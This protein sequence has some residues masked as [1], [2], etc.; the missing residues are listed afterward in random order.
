MKNRYRRV[1]AKALAALAWASAASILLPTR[2]MAATTGGALP[3]DTT[4]QTLSDDIQGPVA[5]AVTA[6]A[7]VMG[8][9]LWAVSEHGQGVRK[10]SAI[11]MGGAMALGALQVMAALFPTSAALI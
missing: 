9:I 4:L 7:V 3:W 6:M 1:R 5:H 2:V 8:G 11:A 10:V